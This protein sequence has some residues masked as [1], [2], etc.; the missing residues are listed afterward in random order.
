MS[1]LAAVAIVQL[2]AELVKVSP[3]IAAELKELFSK[4]DPTTLDF[5]N[6]KR[7]VLAMTLEEL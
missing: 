6:L 1:P 2:L 3:A 5:E 4:E 7:R